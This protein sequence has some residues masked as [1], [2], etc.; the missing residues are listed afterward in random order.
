MS[1]SL[2]ETEAISAITGHL[3]DQNFLPASGAPYTLAHAARDAGVGGLWPSGLSK[4]AALSHLLEGTLSQQRGKFC[5]LIVRIVRGALNYRRAKRNPLKRAEV[6]ELNRLILGVGFKIPELWDETF[7]SRL[8]VPSVPKPSQQD[9]NPNASLI[10]KHT[11]K[12]ELDDRLNQL[13]QQFLELHTAKDR[14]SAGL[15]L[16]KLLNHLF[17][18][19][20]LSPERPFR[21][22]GEQIDGSFV[23]DGQIYLIEAKWHKDAL[24]IKELYTFRTKV[25]TKSKFTRGLF[26]SINGFTEPAQRAIIQGQAPNFIMMDGAHLFRVL[27]NNIRLDEL[28]RR[29]I[30]ICSERGRPYCPIQD[31]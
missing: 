3:Y 9:A 13:K 18:L 19:F 31:L 17:A 30:R 5:E 23:L 7:L 8:D 28:L 11:L 15:E 1:L 25:D 10:D 14:Q 27:E 29:L 12:K 26:L 6:E 2:R 22:E 16:E 24:D 4:R 20:D 21:I